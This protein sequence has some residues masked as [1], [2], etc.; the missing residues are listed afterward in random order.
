M[1]AITRKEKERE[2][3]RKDII[4]AAEK[5]FFAKGFGYAT[6][7]DVAKAAEF[8][9]RTVYVYF[10]SKEQLYFEIMIRGYKLLNGMCEKALGESGGNSGTDKLRLLGKTLI[11]FEHRHPEYFKAIM[12]YENGDM[13]FDNND[14]K[15]MEECYREGERLF[16]FLKDALYQGIKEGTVLAGID[17]ISTALALWASM[18]GVLNTSRRKEKYL[19]HYHNRTPEKL[20]EEAFTLLLRSIEK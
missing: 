5:I 3:R 14:D 19:L 16:G 12:D 13:D 17:V 20:I 9:K 4:D 2:I 15:S 6:M 7:D 11:D 10:R 18:V 1:G 8:S